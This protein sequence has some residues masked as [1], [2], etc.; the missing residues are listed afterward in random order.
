MLSTWKMTFPHLA[1]RWR[2]HKV[3]WM[4]VL[5]WSHWAAALLF[6]NRIISYPTRENV[7][8]DENSLIWVANYSSLFTLLHLNHVVCTL[9]GECV[10]IFSLYPHSSS[11]NTDVAEI[12]WV[13]LT[14]KQPALHICFAAHIL[15]SW[16]LC[17]SWL[18]AS[19]FCLS[20]SFSWA[21]YCAMFALIRFFSAGLL[22]LCL[23]TTITS[24]P[25]LLGVSWSLW[26]LML[27]Y[28]ASEK[29]LIKYFKCF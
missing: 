5:Y 17:W 21:F 7:T 23:A 2:K 18:W 19:G 11:V 14:D 16:S 15:K 29:K 12:V 24:T 25:F 10:V 20:C 9:I 1:T 4:G 27:A 3:C 13:K 22:L 6:T 28:L 26:F 8:W